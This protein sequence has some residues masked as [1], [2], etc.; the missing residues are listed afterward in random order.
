MKISTKQELLDHKGEPLRESIENG[1]GTVS[2][3]GLM[4]IGAVCCD[5]LMRTTQES[6]KAAEAHRLAMDFY[7]K[8][9][10]ELTSEQASMVKRAVA[11]GFKVIISGQV[12]GILDGK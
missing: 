9:V 6:G 4:T 10:V 1:D 2:K 7:Q 8:D 12:V 3:G 5:A 11:Q